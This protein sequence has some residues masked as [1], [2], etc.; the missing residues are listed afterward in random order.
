MSFD[1]TPP[2]SSEVKLGEWISEGW[3][4]FVE[5]W[6][7]WV[8]HAAVCA[9]V[10]VIGILPLYIVIFLAGGLAGAAPG[11]S[12]PLI[13]IPVSL[14]WI[15]VM[16]AIT[17]V[18]TC[19]MYNCAFKQLQGG[20]IEFG[21]M[22]SAMGKAPSVFVASVIVGFLS[23]IGI[24]LCVLPAFIVAGLF[25]FTIPL[26]VFGDMGVIEALQASKDLTKQ[27]IWMFT[28]FAFI[29]QLLSQVGSYACYVG[30]LATYPLLFTIA[31][32][33]YRD[34]FGVPGARSFAAPPSANAAPYS[35]QYPG[36]YPAPYP[37]PNPNPYQSPNV[38]PS[39][40]GYSG[41]VPGSQSGTG[42]PSGGSQNIPPG[43]RPTEFESTCNA[44]GA[45]VPSGV[46]FCANCGASLRP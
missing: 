23:M 29:V 36:Q 2:T 34:C 43:I 45:K 3:R 32:I 17:S 46:N 15:F 25:Y 8:L 6:K 37:P 1:Y 26:I 30:L 7:A 14:I 13:L 10:I 28:L 42:S 27:N 18:V 40:P 24:L 16:A 21:D 33:A 11:Q 38:P 19:G 22:F 5:Q 9:V 31:A 4:M 20:K 12:F 39:Q 44:C 41:P 35:P